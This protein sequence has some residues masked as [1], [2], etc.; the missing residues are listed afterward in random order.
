MFGKRRSPRRSRRTRQSRG[1]L[2]GMVCADPRRLDRRAATRNGC[3]ARTRSCIGLAVAIVAPIGDLFESFVKREARNK[4]LRRPVRRAR[5]RARPARRRAVRRRGRV[6]RVGGVRVS[7]ASARP[8]PVRRA[9]A[10]GK[11]DRAS[12]KTRPPRKCDAEW[13]VAAKFRCDGPT[14]SS[15]P[16]RSPRPHAA[17]R[18]RRPFA[19]RRCASWGTAGRSTGCRTGL[20]D[21]FADEALDPPQDADDDERALAGDRRR[22][23]RDARPHVSVPRPAGRLVAA[24]RREVIEEEASSRERVEERIGTGREAIVLDEY[25][26]RAREDR[27][28]REIEEAFARRRRLA[29]QQQPYARRPVF[30]A[31]LLEDPLSLPNFACVIRCGS[32]FLRLAAIALKATARPL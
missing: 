31:Q 19:C 11:L 15:W 5:R 32:P 2:I 8:K 28:A 25:A 27:R 6:L 20:L 10:S 17:A 4:G 16:G 26:S 29:E 30:G 1:S 18:T 22:D 3:P 23:P 12:R 13:A 14:A 21:G 24:P 9:L 7:V